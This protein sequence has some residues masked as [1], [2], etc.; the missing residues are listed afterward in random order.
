MS[1]QPA[2][3]ILPPIQQN[4]AYDLVLR[5]TDAFRGVTVNTI[6]NTFTSDC[7]E[8]TVNQKIVFLNPNDQ[9]DYSVITGAITNVTR[10]TPCKLK[11]NTL[12]YVSSDGLTD[13]QFK[14]SETVGGP[15]V[16]FGGPTDSSVYVVAR[17][18]N[19]TN[20]VIDADICQAATAARVEVA[21]FTCTIPDAVNGV[22]RLTLT[23][24]TT[25]QITPGNY[26]YDLSV[27]PPDGA[28]FYAMRGTINVELTR[29]R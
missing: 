2:T 20:Y 11:F 27:T 16:I 13:D 3:A 12:Y 5:M 18:L 10:A 8:L 6:T 26:V 17:P 7:H 29:S 23:P 19:I 15:A 25:N 21:T 1:Y 24:A 9:T 22:I 28:R 14:I 4:A